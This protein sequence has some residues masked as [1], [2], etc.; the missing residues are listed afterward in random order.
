MQI[1][2]VAIG[3]AIGAIARYLLGLLMHNN[4]GQVLSSTTVVN[5][6]GCFVMGLIFEI[7]RHNLIHNDLRIFICVGILGAFTTFSAFSQE[8]IYLLEKQE[9]LKFTAYIS[10]NLIG[11]LLAAF[12]GIILIKTFA[13]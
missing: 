3:G 10:L 2:Y 6:T 11:S 12:L 7:F 13:K 8:A 1:L 9:V 4:A 5:L